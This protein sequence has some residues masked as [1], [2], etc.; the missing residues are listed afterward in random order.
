MKS[1]NLVVSA[2]ITA[3]L[4]TLCCLPAFLF[5]FFG[6][7]VAGLSFLSELGFL[8]IPLSILTIILLF[9][10]YKKSKNSIICECKNRKKSIIISIGLF[11][12]FFALL[13]YPEFLVYFVD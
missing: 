6:V 11:L 2:V 4:A 13:F 3:V 7:S 12:L 1:I 5:L 10:A 8:R 9:I